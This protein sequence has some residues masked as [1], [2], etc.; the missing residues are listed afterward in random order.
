MMD[1]NGQFPL[2]DGMHMAWKDMDMTQLI[3]STVEI[4]N[5]FTLHDF[6]KRNGVEF[7]IEKNRFTMILPINREGLGK[8]RNV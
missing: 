4:E 7:G 8:D 2:N 1:K 3:I 6:A 5:A